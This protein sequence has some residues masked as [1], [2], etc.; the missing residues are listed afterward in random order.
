MLTNSTGWMAVTEKAVGCLY[1]WCSLWKCLRS[2]HGRSN[3]F[4][5][6]QLYMVNSIVSSEVR[7]L[8]S[9]SKQLQ[10]LNDQ[11]LS[12]ARNMSIPVHSFIESVPIK[13]VGFNHLVVS[14]ESAN[15]GLGGQ[16]FVNENHIN[17]NKPSSKSD[18]LYSHFV[19]F[20]VDNFQNSPNSVKK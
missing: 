19:N 8:S 16:T 1:V 11:F 14:K 5:G 9:S 20:I 2:K 12:V 13:V 6:V 15:L 17:V 10:E 3:A 4:E 18:I 7:E